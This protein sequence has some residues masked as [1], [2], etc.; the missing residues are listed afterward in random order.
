MGAEFSR[1]AL[2]SLSLPLSVQL[3]IFN[4]SCGLPIGL[5][6][7]RR[8]VIGCSVLCGTLALPA[9]SALLWSTA[10][11]QGGLLLASAIKNT[12]RIRLHSFFKP[13]LTRQHVELLHRAE[14]NVSDCLIS[15]CL[16]QSLRAVTG[17]HFLELSVATVRT[18]A[19]PTEQ[20][21]RM[22][23]GP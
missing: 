23:W 11:M 19:L 9:L 7:T 3:S 5:R 16:V 14:T 22:Q 12:L 20:P 13:S 4:L 10:A 6:A 1:R 17:N 21:A 18:Q 15:L 2:L 8:R